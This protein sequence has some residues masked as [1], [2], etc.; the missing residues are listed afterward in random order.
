[1]TVKRNFKVSISGVRG[2]VGETLTPRLTADLAAS[3]GEYVGR[4][5]VVI[6]RDTRPTGELYEQAIIAGL[7]SVGCQP[8]LIGQVP[9]PTVQMIVDE[10]KA[11][12]GIAITASH[13]P[14]EWNAMKFI[15][16]SGIFLNPNEANELFDVYNQQERAF[17]EETD[18]RNIRTIQNPFAI[19]QRRVFKHIDVALIR[20]ARF[21][22]A[23]DPG[24]GVGAFFSRGFLED[25]GC[26]VITLFDETDGIFRRKPEPTAANI[27]ELCTTVREHCCDVGFAQDPDADRLVIVDHTGHP[28]G[29]QTTLALAAEHVLSQTPGKIVVNIQTTKAL[30]DI[31]ARYGA[32]LSYAKVGEINVTTEMIAQGA[33][34]GGEGGS[35]GVIWPA[36]H[37]CRDS[38]TGMGLIL[39]MMA[40]RQQTIQ[41][42]VASLP[43]YVFLN[44]KFPCSASK[45]FELI[46]KLKADYAA[47]SPNSLDG[48]R[49]DFPDG[50][51]IVRASNTEPII[52]ISAE[53]KTAERAQ[54]LMNLF[55]AAVQSM[56]A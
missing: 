36:I 21:K 15:G 40:R 32:E 43:Q 7:L 23:V 53:A 14:V 47:F 3:F 37:P 18:Y 42:L 30:E 27:T 31:A 2:V 56:N 49:V 10:Y 6:G 46:R 28:I 35:G 33:V 41:T 19:H 5:K 25:L 34:I 39:E 12:G 16:A 13:N 1:M 29:E 52:R 48:L 50:W 51:V 26:E 4:G 8:V 11:N 45:S 55:A 9:T 54:T 38:Y 17:V 22:V 24:N 44:E 20:K